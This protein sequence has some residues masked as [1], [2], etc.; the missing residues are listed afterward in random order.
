MTIFH[1]ISESLNR[2]FRYCT[3]RST[4]CNPSDLHKKQ[5]KCWHRIK[6]LSSNDFLLFVKHKIILSGITWLF[7][8]KKLIML[9]TVK[10]QKWHKSTTNYERNN[11]WLMTNDDQWCFD[12]DKPCKIR[13]EELNLIINYN[14]AA[15]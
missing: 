15:H 14:F 10:L 8:I 6:L 2:L 9:N 11:I 12:D 13:L 4:N 3:L 1:P 5:S 7:G